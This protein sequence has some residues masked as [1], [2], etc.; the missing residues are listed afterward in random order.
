MQTLWQDLRQGARSLF[1]R[2]SFTIV[3]VIALALGVGA[4]TAIFS[5]VYAVLLRALPYRD[6]DRLVTVWEHN[7]TRGNAQN[8]I[9]LG[10]FFDW[11]EQ[12]RVFEDMATFFD[13][14]ANLT[15]GGEPEEI[16]S[17]IATP[18]L[19]NILGVNPI[20]GRDFTNDDGKPGAARVVL[21]SFGLWQR[22]FGGDPQIIGRKLLLNGNE[23]TVVG[24]MPPDFNWH[25][26]AGSM[27]R[28][29]AEMWAPWQIDET[30]KRRGGRF[31]SAVARLKP[32]VTPEQAQA[33]MNVIG[34]QLERQYNE[35]NANWGVNVV[36]L[37]KQFTGEIRLA[38]LV[39]LGAVGMVLLIACANVAN[40]LLARAAVRQREIAVRAALGAGRWRI[41]RQLLT[42]SLLL[43]GLG[44][45]AGLAL[46]WWGTDLL[47]SLAPPD[48][49]NLPQVKINAA[50]LG[51]TLGVSMLTGVI[52]GLVPALEATRLN[53]TGSLKESG[54]NIGGGARS[55]RLR[56]S[57]VIAE[58]AL[59]LV[60]LVGAGLLIRSFARLQG[61]DP[62]FN[63]HSLLTMKVSLPGRKYDTDQKRI[64]FFRQ[65]VAQMQSLPGVES[66]GA[67]SFLPFAAPHAGTLV[68]IEGRPKLP[69][70][71][72]LGT[73][74]MVS[75]VNYFRTMQVPLKRGRLFTDQEAA[76]M[77]HVVVVNEAFARTNFPGEDPLGKRVTIYMKNDNQPCEII[78][79][80]GDSKHMNLDAEV[81]P[82]SYWPHP[83]L[84]YSGMTLVIR[85]K[86]E[87]T[88]I[89]GA[90]RNV[91]RTL[92]PE[93]P[94]ADV[95]T[96]ESLI[97]TSVARARFNTLLL[98]IF[99]T[100]AL[101]LA[102]LGIYGVMAYSVAQ[103]T[104][105]IGVRMALGARAT[106]VL[107]LVV[108]RG[109]ALALAGVAIGVA[110]S[111]ALTWLMKTLLFNVS[112]TDPLTFAGIPLLLIFVALMA[113]LIPARRAAKVDPMVAL[114]YE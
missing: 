30:M 79:V 21:L 43:A 61:V 2:P 14:T 27:T 13:M 113:C 114:R 106:D 104:H 48:L 49:L 107:R 111:F 93:Q 94:V 7:K 45:L 53:L 54:K 3:A 80:V 90:A 68:E 99:S 103:R 18:N 108:R 26:K 4:N 100:V 11:K 44:G 10:N 42:E 71:Q 40:L 105:E 112:A 67:V 24:V 74:V 59:A 20:M 78:G 23:T 41:V 110:A 15:S 81:K 57:L 6:S 36:P 109:M 55:H 46:A 28:K 87:P 69:P 89:A 88:A 35:F 34:G 101:L 8:V 29:M 62:G 96:M 12:N 16:P 31:A 32:G 82:M 95:R 51:F 5:V 91:I 65:A 92:D 38:L 73:G 9:N 1:K 83:E 33:E 76:E 85:T 19:F 75:D 66:A 17:Q 39:L 47:V 22:R 37:R 102:G 64:S 86:G 97:G 63:A 50:V 84:T 72:G 52:F 70:G 77:R 56:N 25:V 98:T 58:I 60:L